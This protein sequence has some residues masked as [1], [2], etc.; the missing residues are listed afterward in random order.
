MN[1]KTKVAPLR[2]KKWQ[3]GYLIALYDQ[4]ERELNDVEPFLGM[5]LAELKCETGREAQSLE[6]S[7]GEDAVAFAKNNAAAAYRRLMRVLLS[8]K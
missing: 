7:R 5:S 8:N 6:D 1:T 2:E 3:L 4:L